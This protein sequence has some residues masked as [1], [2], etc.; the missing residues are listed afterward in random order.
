MTPTKKISVVRG[1][2]IQEAISFLL[3]EYADVLR[4]L[5]DK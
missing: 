4:D 2:K 5:A 1:K 3:R